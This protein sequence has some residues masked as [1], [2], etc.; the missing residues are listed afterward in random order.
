MLAVC[1]FCLNQFLIIVSVLTQLCLNKEVCKKE[2]DVTLEILISFSGVDRLLDMLLP[3]NSQLDSVGNII[4]FKQDLHM[5][6]Q[7]LK[8]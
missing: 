1:G 7:L 2:T 6:I 4:L 8:R 5:C 3:G